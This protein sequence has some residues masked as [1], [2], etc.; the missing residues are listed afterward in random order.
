VTARLGP[1]QG[2][3]AVSVRRGPENNPEGVPR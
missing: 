1:R 2:E 3:R